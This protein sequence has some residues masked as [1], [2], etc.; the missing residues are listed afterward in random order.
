MNGRQF[1]Q[2]IIAITMVLAMTLLAGCGA[3]Q[4][5][6]AGVEPLAVGFCATT[7]KGPR[8]GVRTTCCDQRGRDRSK[9][10]RFIRCATHPF[11]PA[12]KAQWAVRPSGRSNP[13]GAL[14]PAS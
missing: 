7:R 3:P 9:N 12:A 5:P 1:S 4:P 8:Q 6:A 2:Y 14:C 10:P 11:P 13:D